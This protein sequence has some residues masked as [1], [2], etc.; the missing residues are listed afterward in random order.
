[1]PFQKGRERTGGRKK[2]SPNKVTSCVREALTETFTLV[3][4][5][6]ALATWARENPTAFYTLWVKM[7]PAKTEV[8]GP[9]GGAI[10]IENRDSTAQREIERLKEEIALLDAETA[11]VPNGD[12]AAI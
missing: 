8:S 12:A 4:D 3:G 10:P 5:V 2:G 11:P 9:D 1:M 6:P 7:M